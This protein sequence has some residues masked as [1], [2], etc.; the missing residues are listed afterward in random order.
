MNIGSGLLVRCFEELFDCQSCLCNQTAQGASCHFLMIG[1]R[2]SGN[3][4]W[5]GHDD[6][7][8]L[9]ANHLP[10]KAL[11]HLDHVGRGKEGNRRH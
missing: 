9:L 8:A 10:T 5:S 2:K 6:M 7:T 4:T 3:V 1:Y 11:K